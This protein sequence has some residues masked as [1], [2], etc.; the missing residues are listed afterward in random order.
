MIRAVARSRNARNYA[1][2]WLIG[3]LVGL[4]GTDA[5]Y[6]LAAR[7]GG[8]ALLMQR[9]NAGLLVM[10]MVALLIAR[11]VIPFFAMSALPGLKIPLRTRSGQVQL[12][13]CAAAAAF[14]LAGWRL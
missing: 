6:L 5:L 14:V 13:A 12:A 9:F 1:V 8:Y 3:G 2:P 11:R 10:A 7:G 4:A